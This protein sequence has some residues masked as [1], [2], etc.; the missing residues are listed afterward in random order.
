MPLP[1]Q[2]PKVDSWPTCNNRNTLAKY[3]CSAVVRMPRG[4]VVDC[5][6]CFFALDLGWC[7]RSNGVCAVQDA[8]HTIMRSCTL[9]VTQ[10]LRMYKDDA[11]RAEVLA[12]P[13][14]CLCYSPEG[15]RSTRATFVSC[16]GI[17]GRQ[18]AQGGCA[19]QVVGGV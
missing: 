17:K 7:S 19:A 10:P 1:V 16:H 14:A 8:S 13:G 11:A 12:G 4:G 9:C 18:P 5:T 2:S 15:D 6:R 3:P